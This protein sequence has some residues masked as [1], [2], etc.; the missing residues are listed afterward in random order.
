MAHNHET[1][2]LAAVRVRLSLCAPLMYRL[3]TVLT[4]QTDRF[5]PCMV[6]RAHSPV[7]SERPAHNR[8]VKCSNHFGPI[9]IVSIVVVSRPSKPIARVQSSHDASLKRETGVIKS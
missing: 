5:D 9:S 6:H 3:H 4:P 2:R 7:W 1:E 8:D